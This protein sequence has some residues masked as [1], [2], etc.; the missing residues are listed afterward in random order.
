MGKGYIKFWGVR[1]SH[2]TADTDKMNFGGDTSCVEIR[3]NDKMF[4]FDMGSGLR[5]LGDSMLKD[6]SCP[7]EVHIFLS[8]YHWDHIMGYLYFKPLFDSSFSFNIYGTNKNIR[9]KDITS[10]LMQT[11]MWPVS[12]DMLKAK[13]N[14]IELNNSFL[15]IKL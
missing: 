8:H 1:G 11:S 3:C 15:K 6:E 10:K 14:F 12:S 4:I 7:K 5:N 13:I 9:I 2:P